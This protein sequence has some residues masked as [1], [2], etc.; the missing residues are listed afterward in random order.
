MGNQDRAC[1]VHRARRRGRYP[2]YGP[3]IHATED[4]GRYKLAQKNPFP[5]AKNQKSREDR[6]IA[7]NMIL[8]AFR[9]AMHTNYTYLGWPP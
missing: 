6:K 1:S 2:H 7:N 4:S 3:S 8:R 9:R 5:D